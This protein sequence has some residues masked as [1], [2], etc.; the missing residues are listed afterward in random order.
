MTARATTMQAAKVSGTAEVAKVATAVPL[1]ESHRPAWE[2]MHRAYA[3]FYKVPRL[4][5]EKLERL[6][7]W[8]S[9]P[10]DS[11]RG[12][13]ALVENTPSGFAHFCLQRNPLRAA[14]T[15]Y[16]HDLYVAPEFRGMRVGEQLIAAVAEIAR[17]EGC[18]R[19]RWATMSDNT[20][21]RKLYDRLA[22]KTEW[23]VYD[24][25]VA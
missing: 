23:V 22:R 6:W 7:G 4:E 9:D 8:L 16:L 11:M 24:M 15:M 25:D 1:S 18:F 20:P 12:L 5:G 3:D 19:L 14:Q 21:A 17:T 10:S 2:A 13:V